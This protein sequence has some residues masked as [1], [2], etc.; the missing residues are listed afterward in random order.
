ML[1][2]N[3]CG[4][5]PPEDGIDRGL[6]DHFIE[7]LNKNRFEPYNF[8]RADLGP[9]GSFGG[10]EN[11]DDTVVNEPII[12]IHGNSDAALGYRPD[13]GETGWTSSIKY[14]LS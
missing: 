4:E 8:N 12:F 9:R 7:W 10:K 2:K 14:F 5:L 13:R 3:S 11:D 6:T 1:Y